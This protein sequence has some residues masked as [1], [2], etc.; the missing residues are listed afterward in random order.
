M[1]SIRQRGFSLIELMIVVAI[2]G[3]LAAIAVPSYQTYVRKAKLVELIS[4]VPNAQVAIAEYVQ[5]TGDQ[6]CTNLAL[7]PQP[8]V[9]GSYFYGNGSC[10]I[11]IYDGGTG[12]SDNDFGNPLS[13]SYT[14]T[15]G[16]DGS[17]TWQCNYSYGRNEPADFFPA[18]CVSF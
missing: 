17:I 7:P 15:F 10:Q 8:A 9:L 12:P 14:P 11:Q 16:S 2:M 6:T 13:I 5:S 3:I 18:G 1:N 4:F